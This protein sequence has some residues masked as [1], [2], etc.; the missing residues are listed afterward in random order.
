MIWILIFFAMEALQYY[1]R[2]SDD[3]NSQL[4]SKIG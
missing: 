3:K 4:F 2:F 1:K